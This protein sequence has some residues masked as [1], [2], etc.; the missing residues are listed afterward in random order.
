MI[1]GVSVDLVIN[2][3]SVKNKRTRSAIESLKINN[4]RL[5]RDA[6][7]NFI[8][9]DLILNVKILAEYKTRDK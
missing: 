6:T 5:I 4:F 8:L 9:H 2:N 1:D 3:R 7:Q